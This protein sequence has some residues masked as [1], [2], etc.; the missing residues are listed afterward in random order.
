MEKWKSAESNLISENYTTSVLDKVDI[1]C[2]PY[3]PAF[4]TVESSAYHESADNSLSI[5]GPKNVHDKVYSP[6]T[7]RPA[8][9]NIISS[10]FHETAGAASLYS[11]NCGDMMMNETRVDED[12]SNECRD[13]MRSTGS[14]IVNEVQSTAGA[15]NADDNCNDRQDELQMDEK[16]HP[17]TPPESPSPESHNIQIKRHSGI[18]YTSTTVVH[19]NLEPVPSLIFFLKIKRKITVQTIK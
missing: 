8:F 5:S 1:P 12:G 4:P 19:N 9:S 3:Y 15:S 7:Q 13:D 18:I 6:H 11:E 14:F 10:T 2:T 16:F 17:L